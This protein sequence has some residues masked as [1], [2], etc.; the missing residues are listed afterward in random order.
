MSLPFLNTAPGYDEELR[1]SVF[2]ERG[3]HATSICGAVGAAVA[4]AM[5]QGQD[6]ARSPPPPAS[7]PAWAPACW[8]PTAPAGPSSGSTAAGP[9]AAAWQR[10]TWPGTGS[11]ARRPCWR[12]AS[13]SCRR[14]AATAPTRTPSSGGLGTDWELPRVVFKPYPCNH[15]TH[16]GV[17]AALRLRAQ[18]LPPPTSERSSWASPSPSCARSPSHPRARHGGVQRPR[19]PPVRRGAG[20]EVPRQRREV[21]PGGAR[22][23][24]RISNARP[25]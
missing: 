18:G 23:R 16:A 22:G 4:V 1:N 25:S 20:E 8:R 7:R 15:F 17:G 21:P 9:R 11:P 10:P 5:L 24:A 2:F 12:A 14:S 13:G 19:Q 6:E 3:L